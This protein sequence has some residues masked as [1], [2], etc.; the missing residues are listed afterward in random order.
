MNFVE[1]RR[2]VTLLL[3]CG[4]AVLMIVNGQSTTDNEADTNE[5]AVLRAELANSV[6]RIAKLESHLAAAI[7]EIAKRKGNLAAVAANKPVASCKSKTGR[8][9]NTGRVRM[10]L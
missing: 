1:C 8:H 6:A 4:S 7:G 2:L 9:N 3:Y 5:N 10:R